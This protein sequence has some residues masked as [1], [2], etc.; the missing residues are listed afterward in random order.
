ML[1]G[2]HTDDSSCRLCRG[3]PWHDLLITQLHERGAL[4]VPVAE[5]EIKAHRDVK[6]LVQ[7]P[8]ASEQDPRFEL[9]LPVLR[10]SEPFATQ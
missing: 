6:S 8:T 1:A 4:I 2:F 5:E 10:E 3:F 9:R 7:G